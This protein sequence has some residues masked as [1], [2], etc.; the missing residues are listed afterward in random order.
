LRGSLQ[1]LE[2][3][4]KRDWR[5]RQNTMKERTDRF[6]R[7][8]IITALTLAAIAVATSAGLPQPQSPARETPY[9]KTD[10]LMPPGPPL[11]PRPVTARLPARPAALVN[12]RI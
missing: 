9:H 10:P 1:V 6:A 5:N 2:G 8:T 7:F 3:C 4:T 12:I 11:T